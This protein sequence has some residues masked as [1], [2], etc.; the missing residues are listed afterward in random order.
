MLQS[1]KQNSSLLKSKDEMMKLKTNKISFR[2]TPIFII[3]FIFFTSCSSTVRFHQEKKVSF[4]KIVSIPDE[5]V[6]YMQNLALMRDTIKIP[7]DA[8]NLEIILPPRLIVESLRLQIGQKTLQHFNIKQKR[9]TLVRIRDVRPHRQKTISI[10]YLTWGIHWSAQYRVNINKNK[11]LNVQLGAL[12]QNNWYDLNSMKVTLVA[13][14]VGAVSSRIAQK[15]K[16]SHVALASLSFIPPSAWNFSNFLD[17]SHSFLRYRKN[18]SFQSFAFSKEYQRRYNIREIRN[19]SIYKKSNFQ[20][21]FSDYYKEKISVNKITGYY[22]YKGL[23]V[24]ARLREKSLM[25]VASTTLKTNSYYIWPADRRDNALIV[26]KIT[27]K[28]KVLFPAG[29][30]WLYRDGIFV[31]QDTCLWTPVGASTY[32]TTSNDGLISVHKTTTTL[33][34]ETIHTTLKVQ[35]FS[36]TKIIVE[37]FDTNPQRYKKGKLTFTKK[38]LTAN[39]NNPLHH[40]KIVVKPHQ[41]TNVQYSFKE[42]KPPKIKIK[43]HKT[44]KIKRQTQRTFHKI[45]IQRKRRIP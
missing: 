43:F 40:W 13:G 33:K 10:E 15:P 8:Q 20:K 28:S 41:I 19:K 35:S 16:L 2:T 3:L 7:D 14:W 9:Y 44:Q 25:Q 24:T 37:I 38:P 36:D 12:I 26:Y 30:A 29:S 21:H 18:R 45:Q 4:T 11:T 27:N 32:L 23:R 42:F 1:L 22:L 39:K 34:D 6:I 17:I 5:A 31:G